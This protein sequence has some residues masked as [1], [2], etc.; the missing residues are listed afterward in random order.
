MTISGWPAV[1][2]KRL[3][4]ACLRFPRLTILASLAIYSCL[5]LVYYRRSLPLKID[6]ASGQR[7]DGPVMEKLLVELDDRNLGDRAAEDRSISRLNVAVP[8]GDRADSRKLLEGIFYKADA[9][10]D[11]ALDI[12]ELA[13]W[14]HAKIIDHIDRAM[15]DNI[16][17]FTAIDNNPRNGEDG[18]F[19]F[20]NILVMVD[21]FK[22]F[23][24]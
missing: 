1:R 19:I 7:P 23:I 11:R 4:V 14:I 3:D 15:R 5:L 10:G 13:K 21:C 20:F 6:E 8:P 9:D 16:G 24:L 22:S 18:L 12:R 2:M 17:L